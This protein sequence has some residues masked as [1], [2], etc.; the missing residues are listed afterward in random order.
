MKSLFT[1]VVS[2]NTQWSLR[3]SSVDYFKAIKAFLK[4]GIKTCLP[5]PYNAH[6]LI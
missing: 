3:M 6:E 2:A 1:S 4:A 5:P